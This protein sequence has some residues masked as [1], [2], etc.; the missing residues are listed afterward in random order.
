MGN[1]QNVIS[2]R[3]K[4]GHTRNPAGRPKMGKTILKELNIDFSLADILKTMTTFL[5]MSKDSLKIITSDPES[6]CLEVVLASAICTDINKGRIT[7]LEAL[8]D[9]VYGKPKATMEIIE[10]AKAV[11]SIKEL[12]SDPIEA[13]KKY[14]ELM[15]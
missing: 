11:M 9:R 8:L 4:K 10:P 13:S 6:S 3:I 15:N 12:T 5:S 2:R 7:V 14:Q 1:P